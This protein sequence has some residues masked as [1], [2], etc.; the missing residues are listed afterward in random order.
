[1]AQVTLQ[2]CF[3]SK[4]RTLVT[5][6]GQP[7]MTDLMCVI[8]TILSQDEVPFWNFSLVS[9]ILIKRAK[10]LINVIL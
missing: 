6:G 8:K 7:V 5:V 10:S 4:N 9:I 2:G 3:G 1:M